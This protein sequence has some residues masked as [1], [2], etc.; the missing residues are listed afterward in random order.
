MKKYFTIAI[1]SCLIAAA[2]SLT[3]YLN[4]PGR[5][6]KAKTFGGAK[7]D[8]AKDLI[9]TSDGY[10]LA[11]MTTSSGIGYVDAFL[12]KLDKRGNKKWENTFGGQNDDRIFSV[13][14]TENGDFAAAGYTSSFGAG[15]NDF[16]LI[17]T[18]S[19]GNLKYAK[20]FGRKGRDEAYSII[21]TPDGGF[22]LA[23]LSDSFK[24]PDLYDIY[25]VRTDS[26]GNSL[27]TRAIG[28]K[29]SDEAACV[30]DSKDNGFIVAGTTSSFGVKN[31]NIIMLKID[32]RGNTL[33]MKTYGGPDDDSCSN[34]IKLSSG[35]YAL[36]GTTTSGQK[37][38]SDILLVET[39]A[40]GNS[41]WSKTFGGSGVD[42]GVTIR[43]CNDGSLVIGATSES[44]S[45]GSSDIALIKTDKSGNISWIKHFG[46]SGDDYLGN[47]QLQE[48]G[49]IA[50]AGWV[51]TG[52]RGNYGAYF[53][54][55][56]KN[57]VF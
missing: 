30:I 14:M 7:Y 5:P 42:Q 43:E 22:L 28:G 51:N 27:W 32:G 35:N 48:D 56:D 8:A 55:T 45:Y 9:I 29:R 24:K 49:G 25:L 52:T 13:I 2:A 57:G 37:R 38:D 33:W 54:K 3:V 1:L 4:L 17:R 10:L 40:Q 20:T 47:I 36:I 11:G 21:Q 31:N 12:M 19:N 41:L 44:Y 46:G 18:D 15:N 39:D 6:I 16:Y 34:V 53:F 26:E 23:G 50:A